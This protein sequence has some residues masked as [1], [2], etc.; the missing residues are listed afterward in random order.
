M[1]VQDLITLYK[2]ERSEA[3]L[4][5]QLFA[6]PRKEEMVDSQQL[7]YYVGDRREVAVNIQTEICFHLK[8]LRLKPMTPEQYLR[9]QEST[10]HMEDLISA[11]LIFP[12][13][14][15]INGHLIRWE[16][17]TII[18]SQERYD[19]LIT[20][21]DQEFFDLINPD[22][23]L[24]VETEVHTLQLPDSIEYYQGGYP[25]D[26]HTLFAFD[27]Q[28]VLVR[29]G[30]AYIR[31]QNYDT[32]VEVIDVA[33]VP[34]ATFI[35]DDDPMFKYFPENVFVFNAGVYD[36]NADIKVLATAMMI[37]N[38]Q[39]PETE[40][41]NAIMVRI[42][43]NTKLTTP[44]Y[45]N[46][47][48][49]NVNNI[50]ADLF[51]AL[52]ESDTTPEYMTYLAPS[53]DPPYDINKSDEENNT[54]ILNY[55]AEYDFILFNRVYQSNKDFVELEVDYNWV[56]AHLTEDNYLRIPRRFQDGNNFYIMVM[57]NG[58]LYEFYRQS[59]YEFGWFLCP[60]QGM[61]DGDTIELLYF[62]GCKNFV[63]D[64]NIS[65]DE[66]FLRLDPWIY[67]KDLRVFSKYTKE[68]YFTFPDDAQTMF[69]I[70]YSLEYDS[71]DE[72]ALRIRF[73]DEYY[74]GKDIVLANC[75]RFIYMNYGYDDITSKPIQNSDGTQTY[76]VI[77]LSTH[78]HYCNEYDRY[79]IF[80]NG[81]R[82][83]NDFYRLVLP[84]RPTTPFT[85]AMLYLCIPINEGDRV[86]VFYLPHRFH[87]I[88]SATNPP[89]MDENGTITVDKELLDFSLDNQLYSIW[90]NAR[91][92]PASQIRNISS[93]KLQIMTNLT[94]TRDIR[95]TTMISDDEIFDE[96]KD[97]FNPEFTGVI[98]ITINGIIYE[99][100]QTSGPAFSVDNLSESKIRLNNFSSNQDGSIELEQTS[101]PTD[102][103]GD[104]Q[105]TINDET[106]IQLQDTTDYSDPEATT[107][108]T[109]NYVEFSKW[110]KV[111]DLYNDHFTLM[112]ID[113]PTIEN[114]DEAA[115]PNVI[116][117]ISV[118]R[119]IIR[120]WYETNPIVD[121]T[122]PFLYDYGDVDQ[123]AIIGQDPMGNDML[124]VADANQSNNLNIERDWP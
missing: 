56:M 112:G 90:I 13:L 95:V 39:L 36:G 52:Q 41:P 48:K 51:A 16:N 22:R 24:D 79:V 94:S 73:T 70:E 104:I 92:I 69:P 57:V 15:F 109:P 119:E 2:N 32:T 86:D 43:H 20:G 107:G 91:K 116:P 63:L 44:T 87:D 54:N 66:E 83:I 67:N 111:I 12:F 97:R 101:G 81:K 117:T 23:F 21:L 65:L 120:D 1:T 6:I 35:F 82:L 88:W 89:T 113:K 25:V 14:I 99:F 8:W 38:G 68:T 19:M 77:D 5:Q 74:Y 100:T 106:A 64:A 124:D 75:H 28:G 71:N 102:L 76:F 122:G 114:T 33:P 108:D 50:Q 105:V 72:K 85:K 11:G 34:G 59:K 78:F 10:T 103:S 98:K 58:E 27:E 42:F 115:F 37:Y 29:S 110:D 61:Q 62:K 46:I 7:T 55:I 60:T 49:V 26:E 84:Y 18:I 118:M 96:F 121:I 30:E 17:I 31:I 40:D 3:K 93:T 45:D 4:G 9:L 123:S 53:F 47:R 80:F